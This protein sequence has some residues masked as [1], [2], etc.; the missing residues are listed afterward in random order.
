MLAMSAMSVQSL[1]AGRFRLGLGTS[2]PQV[3]EGWHGVEFARPIQRTRET[4]EIIKLVT[5]GARLE[6][7]GTATRLPGKASAK[8]LPK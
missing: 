4:I 2:G 3:I 5:P 1:S 8:T 7:G 6:Y